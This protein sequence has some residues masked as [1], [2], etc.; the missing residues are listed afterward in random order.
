MPYGLERKGVIL[1]VV[2]GSRDWRRGPLENPF[3]QVVFGLKAVD[4][5]LFGNF[6]SPAKKF[7]HQLFKVFVFLD[8]SAR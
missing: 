6:L 3:G 5:H 1:L 2:T 8:S 4:K 7:P